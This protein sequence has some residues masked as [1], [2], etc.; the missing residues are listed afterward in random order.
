MTSAGAAAGGPVRS[1]PW[2]VLLDQLC[3]GSCDL[4]GYVTGMRLG[5]VTAWRP[6]NVT[7]TV[8]PPEGFGVHQEACFG[9]WSAAVLDRYAGLAVFTQLPAGLAVLTR[10]LDVRF[11]RPLRV[12]IV[13]QVT[14]EVL[15]GAGPDLVVQVELAQ[16]G[17]VTSRAVVEQ[18]LVRT[19]TERARRQPAG[20]GA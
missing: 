3:V 10:R 12:S 14:A 4:P 6:G 11:L 20:S 9:G 17:A 7:G 19:S 5:E 2:Q 16:Q 15:E 1:S 13:A 8:V 18:V